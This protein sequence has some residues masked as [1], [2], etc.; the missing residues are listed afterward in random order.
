MVMEQEQDG[1]E[2]VAQDPISQEQAALDGEQG[3]ESVAPQY[4]TVDTLQKMQDDQMARFSQMVA[5]QVGGLQGKVDKGLNAIRRDTQAESAERFKEAESRNRESFLRN[6]EDPDLRSQMGQYL[7]TQDANWAERAQA[8]APIIESESPAPQQQ[9][10]EA[11]WNQVFAVVQE[12]GGDPRDPRINYNA[13]V[14][15]TITEPTRRERFFKSLRDTL[16]TPPPAPAA[17]QSD[18][19]QGR[20]PVSPPI[21]G[22]ERRSGGYRSRED[23]DRA[24]MSDGISRDEYERLRTQYPA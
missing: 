5:S 9:D 13:L 24:Y 20:Q 22:G 8:A 12:L 7:T 3:G 2:Q 1:S 19:P 16:K 17:Q 21:E 10:N 23:V 4:V 15:E 6:I 14:D 11:R 18:Q